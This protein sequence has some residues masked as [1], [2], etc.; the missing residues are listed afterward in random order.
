[1]ISEQPTPSASVVTDPVRRS[2][3]F[4]ENAPCVGA[5]PKG[6]KPKDVQATARKRSASNSSPQESVKSKSRKL[7]SAN[8]S[9]VEMAEAQVTPILTRR[10]KAK[11]EED[12]S[13]KD[14]GES[15]KSETSS[16]HAEDDNFAVE[17]DEDLQNV[18]AEGLVADVRARGDDRTGSHCRMTQKRKMPT[19][20][21]IMLNPPSR[22][23][24]RA[25]MSS[26][27][28]SVPASELASD[29]GEESDAEANAAFTALSAAAQRVP[30][31]PEKRRKFVVSGPSET[32]TSSVSYGGVHKERKDDIQTRNIAGPSVQDA[33]EDRWGEM[34]AMEAQR[35]QGFLPQDFP[36]QGNGDIDFIDQFDP[37]VDCACTQVP[38]I[39]G[40]YTSQND[41]E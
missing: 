5:A 33:V 22:P 30:P 41:R 34:V 39:Q 14:D 13:D 18:P 36:Y 8:L 7:A 3:I 28:L 2:K 1:M 16:N 40:R 31:V 9:D 11:K 25:S 32:T 10:K 19:T 4:P 35:M 37:T 27:Y 12:L 15:E 38:Q 29:S 21:P 26:G 6:P 20:A 24:S 17:E 23:S